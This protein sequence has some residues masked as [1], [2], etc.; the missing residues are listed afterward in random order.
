M[1]AKANAARQLGECPCRTAR[2]ELPGHDATLRSRPRVDV[3]KRNE[4]RLAALGNREVI[5][6]VIPGN[7]KIMPLD[8]SIDATSHQ[9]A[10]RTGLTP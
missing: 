2:P 6:D 1:P 5:S 8:T 9:K 4:S 3:V 10:V 7:R